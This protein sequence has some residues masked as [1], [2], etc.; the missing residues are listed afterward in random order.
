MY[1]VAQTWFLD[2]GPFLISC[3]WSCWWYRPVY[4]YG[5]AVIP[6]DSDLKFRCYTHWVK[7]YGHCPIFPFPHFKLEQNHRHK[8]ETVEGPK[9]S[10]DRKLLPLE[11]R[12]CM[13]IVKTLLLLPSLKWALGRWVKDVLKIRD[14]LPS[15]PPPQKK[16]NSGDPTLWEVVMFTV[17]AKRRFV[18]SHRLH[19]HTW[20]WKRLQEA[21]EVHS[22]SFLECPQSCWWLFWH[23]RWCSQSPHFSSEHKS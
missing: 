18:R 8:I 19:L 22:S 20:W 15:P 6:T 9:P 21:R 16:K 17:F 10:H 2:F 13:L 14:W 3:A 12:L 5:F 4:P 1:M 23:F 11:Y 7:N